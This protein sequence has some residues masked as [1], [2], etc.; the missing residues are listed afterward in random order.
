MLVSAPSVTVGGGVLVAFE[1]VVLVVLVAVGLVLV[2]ARSVTVG[3]G[4]LVAFE[5][6]SAHGATGFVLSRQ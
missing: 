4:V 5:L 1:L 6:V 3:G 2:S